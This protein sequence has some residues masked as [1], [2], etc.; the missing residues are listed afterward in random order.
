MS[1]T[2]IA[3]SKSALQIQLRTIEAESEKES[4]EIMTLCPACKTF[5]AVWFNKGQLIQN[6]KLTRFGSHIYHDCDAN[7]PCRL[8]T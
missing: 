6:R 4:D 3:K 7:M 1:I 5:E 8:Y 2:I